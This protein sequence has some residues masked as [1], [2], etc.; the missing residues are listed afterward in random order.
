MWSP[1]ARARKWL[2]E[3]AAAR[4]FLWLRP[5]AAAC[6][7]LRG[8]RRTG[9]SSFFSSSFQTQTSS[10]SSLGGV[11]Q[12]VQSRLPSR[13]SQTFRAQR[14]LRSTARPERNSLWLLLWQLAAPS[15]ATAAAAPTSPTIDRPPWRFQLSVGASSCAL[16]HQTLTL[17][18][19]LPMLTLWSQNMNMPTCL[20]QHQLQLPLNKRL[21]RE[22]PNNSLHQFQLHL[23]TKLVLQSRLELWM[24]MI[25]AFW[26]SW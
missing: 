24:R 22:S 11:R 25:L 14:V 21:L 26:R 3:R 10:A 23:P 2:A 7:S 18:R 15:A 17:M 6:V 19:L 5:V 8:T 16:R 4:F 20:H 12:S 9:L 13:P 1:T